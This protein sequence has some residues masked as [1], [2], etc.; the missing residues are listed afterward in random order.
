MDFIRKMKV[1]AL[2]VIAVISVASISYAESAK[3]NKVKVDLPNKPEIWEIHKHLKKEDF[4]PSTSPSGKMDD[5]GQDTA[6]RTLKGFVGPNY[7][8]Q[9]NGKS[10][11]VLSNSLNV[12]KSGNW[13]VKGLVRNET[14]SN[15]GAVTIEAKLISSKGT[16]LGT[17]ST[18]SIVTKIRP[19]EPAPFEMTS[20]IPVS[21][22]ASV[23]WITK[24]TA[25]QDNISREANIMVDYE[26]AYGQQDYRGFKRNDPPYPYVLATSFDNLSGPIKT[27]QL[28]AAW[29]DETG[30][31]VWIGTA[32]LDSAFKNGV[33]VDGS[34]TFNNIVVNN[35][36]IAPMLSQIPYTLWVIAK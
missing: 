5:S 21:K 17:V 18:K 10:V 20:S 24:P 26:L 32:S 6:V 34:A 27:A 33:G 35:S 1:V 9:V 15:I 29:L 7:A 16:L 25:A 31:V 13:A 22:V 2:L 4:D 23:Q 12:S 14:T 36:K 28:V 3:S 8:T 30:K 19:G 11:I